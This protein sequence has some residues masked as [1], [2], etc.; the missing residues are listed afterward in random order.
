M[1]EVVIAAAVRTPVGKFGGAF[2]SLGALDLTIP[3]IRSLVKT[4]GIDAGIVEDVIW[5]CNYQ[6]TYRENNLAR[7]AAVKAGL[8]VSV[9]GITL[10]RNCTSSMSA[11]QMAYYQIKCGEADVIMAGG[12]DSM[13][14][15]AY[16][17]EKMRNGARMGHTEVRDSMWDSLTELGIGPAMGITAENLAEKYDISRQAQDQ[18]ALTSHQRAVAAMDQG[19]FKDEILPLEVRAKKETRTVDTDEHPRRD[20]SLEGLARLKPA[21][22]PDGTVTAGNASGI[23]DG[24]AGILLMSAEKARELNLP[25]LAVVSATATV[26]VDPEIM[27]IGPV[28]AIPKALKKAGFSLADIDLF[29]INEAFAAQ[30]LACEKAL[31]LNREITNVNGSG[32]SLGHPVG[33]TG[34]RITTTL[35]FEMKRRNL[36]KGVASL[37]AGGGM[38]AALV[39][40]RA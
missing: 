36:N 30:Y 35:L 37:C 16:T 1:K 18:L 10:H 40:E 21:F 34:A 3:V 12:T 19:R 17:I 25:V 32:I 9:A 5:G 22:K 26:G 23:N 24:A 29:E 14:N 15:A 31:E 8:P 6:K 27:G 28:E 33:A 38:G 2:Q 7:V 11:I 4:T 20:V 13:S 39:V